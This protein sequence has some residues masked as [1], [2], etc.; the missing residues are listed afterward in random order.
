M[1]INISKPDL[2]AI[3]VRAMISAGLATDFTTEVLRDGQALTESESEIRAD[4][5]IRDMRE[6]LWS[7]IDN[8]ESRDLDQI[9]YVERLPDGRIWLL[10]GIADV[11]AFVPKGSVIDRRAFVN[12][13]SVYTPAVIFPMLPEQLSTGITSLLEGEDRL[14]LV[15]ELVLTSEGAVSSRDVYRALVHNRAKLTYDEVGGWLENQSQI[16]ASIANVYG[17]EEQIRLQLET[18]NLLHA[19]RKQ[20][21]ALELETVEVEPVLLDGEVIRLDIK[22]HNRAQQIIENF[23]IAANTSMAEFLQERGVP[24]L[25]RVVRTPERWNLIVKMAKSYGVNLPWRPD[26]RALSDFLAQRRA[27]APAKYI[28]LSLA[29][30]KMMGSGEYLVEAPGLE[31]EGHFGLAVHDYTHST[32]PNRRYPDLITQRCLKAAISGESFP[33]TRSEL[34]EI[35]ERCNRMEDAARKVERMTKKAAVAVLLSG[36]VGEIFDGI[37]TGVKEKGTFLQ[38]VS[39]P[40]DGR[41]VKGEEGLSVGEK[42]RVKLVSTEPERGFIDFATVKHD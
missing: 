35:A 14:A 20:N 1:T 8:S 25:R 2:T 3:A 11:D 38:L 12:T 9:E 4:G 24:S 16:P 29:V 17:L 36:R 34:E 19:L 18:T 23:M 31:Q 10:I 40:A 21:G 33:Y 6:L 41:I 30:L 39:L 32:A 15:I 13:V 7:S 42:V 5:P 37:V 26:S 27:K 28:D 22:R